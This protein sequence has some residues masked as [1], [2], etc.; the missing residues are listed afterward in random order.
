[1]P[2]EAL[3]AGK[4]NLPA[5]RTTFVGREREM[6]EVKRTLAMT[7][8]LTLTGVG[9]SGKTRLALEVA[10]DLVGAYPEGVWVVELA[11]LSE[12]DL[13]PQAVASALGVQEQPAQPLLDTLAEALRVKEMLLV[14]DNCEHLV[15]A[16]ASLVDA[17]LSSCPHLHVL[18]TSREALDVAGE[19]RWAVPSLSVPAS[20]SSLTAQELEGYASARLFLERASD[21]RPGFA[22]TTENARAVAEICRRLD[23]I[24]LAI[25][26]AAARVGALSVEQISERLEDSLKLLTDGGR[27]T[28]PRQRTLRGALDWSYELL[29]EQERVL[30]RR[31][32]VFA[33]G[34]TLE[35]AEAV[36]PGE[37]VDQH[38]FVDLLSE[39]VD[40]SLLV[41][42]TTGES[43]V[44][45][46]LLEP[47]RQYVRE[48]LEES[49]EA[50]AVQRRRA[51]F[52]LALAE[53]AGAA[54]RGSEEG[55]WLDHLEAEHDNIRAVFSYSLVGG[56]PGLGLRMAAALWWFCHVRGYYSEG[57]TWLE[58]ALAG[59]GAEN[60]TA[61]AGALIGLGHML[62]DRDDFLRA[63]ECL[64]EALALYERVGDLGGVA[65]ALNA[66]G[67]VT[68]Q[69]GDDLGQGKVLLEESLAAARESGNR[70][71]IP[72]VL[73]GLAHIA[74]ENG[75]LELARKLWGDALLLNRNQG[76]ASVTSSILFNLGYIELAAREVVQ[77]IDL[78]AEALSL[79]RELGHK[80]LVASCLLG[81][82][83]AATLQGEP[84]R[85]EALIKE[86]LQINL[87]LGSKSAIAEFLEG[88]AE[89]AGALGQDLRAAR[90]WGAAAALRKTLDWPW[91]TVERRLHEPLLEAARSRLKTAW[92]AAF[93]EG[94]A[95]DLEEAATYA[96]SDERPTTPAAQAP[97]RQV[98]KARPPS[99]TPREKEVATLVAQGLTNRK[100]AARLVISEFTA[101]THLAR[102]FKKL[103]LRSR[104]QLAVWV[105]GRGRSSNSG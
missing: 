24:P 37:G 29:R 66:L 76:R 45:Y 83:M 8:L 31:L 18:A 91:W 88:L 82:G 67:W 21:R 94:Q 90:L 95:M 50:E 102:I 65:E 71:V 7:R 35:A 78:F 55:A 19:V 74:I 85:G 53:E 3:G 81:L 87:E 26:L 1:L 6:L 33:G 30:F 54:L 62:S 77:A 39:L 72:S 84:R 79:S 105:N 44:R 11:S 86:G 56:D 38:S 99:L 41:V 68:F 104:T 89:A 75:T 59:K 103:G 13:V 61:R 27:T 58:G 23:G 96:L 92:D 43:R 80:Y 69:E 97:D 63:E 49:G 64:E 22:A 73:N 5:A 16:A 28:V 4:H 93:D 36:A 46:R 14:L 47:I 70:R 42:E 101:E 60:P 20:R 52:F 12:G 25:E 9:G 51:S 32:S 57:T 17:L 98:S 34:W 15:E 100:I 48:K 2:E 40:K 10:R